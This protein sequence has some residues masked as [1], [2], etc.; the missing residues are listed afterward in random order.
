MKKNE[1]EIGMRP[2]VRAT[3]AP[4]GSESEALAHSHHID[5]VLGKTREHE[6]CERGPSCLAGRGAQ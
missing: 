1:V 3:H 6:F 5:K 4:Y 2:R